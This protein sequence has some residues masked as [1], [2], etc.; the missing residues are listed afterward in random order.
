MIRRARGT[1]ILAAVGAILLL[2]AGHAAAD[3]GADEVQ[4]FCYAGDRSAEEYL[5]TV[6]VYSLNNPAAHCNVMY[7]D[8]NGNCTAC[9]DDE[10]G[11]EVCMGN[12][13]IPYYY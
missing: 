7:S 6:D 2:V 11:R 4:I 3:W 1:P 13:G 8:C 10:S 12:S 9:Y 5:G